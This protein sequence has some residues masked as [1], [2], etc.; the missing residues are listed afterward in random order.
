MWK[1]VHVCLKIGKPDYQ[2]EP[3]LT[4][5]VDYLE[6]VKLQMLPDIN[7]SYL[8]TNCGLAY[9]DPGLQIPNGFFI[10]I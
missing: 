8:H 3:H 4:T 7:W 6:S 2:E 10:F 1:E 9:C 5:C